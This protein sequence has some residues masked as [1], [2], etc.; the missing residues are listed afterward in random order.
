MP[1]A[2]PSLNETFSLLSGEFGHFQTL[3]G[4]FF[5]V[6]FGVLTAATALK[7]PDRHARNAVKTVIAIGFAWFAYLNYGALSEVRE[8]REQ[9]AKY[10]NDLPARDFPKDGADPSVLSPLAQA[11]P[12]SWELKAVHFLASLVVVVLIFL[13]PNVR[14]PTYL[15]HEVTRRR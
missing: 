10:A 14:E 6:T 7:F 2:P 1:A 3:W 15:G 13:A 8:H 12:K 5:A 11:P 9:L 4:A